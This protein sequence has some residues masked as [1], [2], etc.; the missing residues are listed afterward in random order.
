MRDVEAKSMCTESTWN[1]WRPVQAASGG[2]W[3][4]ICSK[5]RFWPAMGHRRALDGADHNCSVAGDCN[6]RPRCSALALPYRSRPARLQAPL[7]RALHHQSGDPG[8]RGE[9]TAPAGG[10]RRRGGGGRQR[11]GS[12]GSGGSRANGGQARACGGTHWRRCEDGGGCA[13]AALPPG[14]RAQGAAG[15]CGTRRGAFST[16]CCI[17]CMACSCSSP[18]AASFTC[19]LLHP[20]SSFDRLQRGWR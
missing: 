1:G 13:G 4:R 6:A 2:A 14:P 20:R 19:R 8:F 7:P 9:P 15:G 12:H 10:W 11:S 16:R 17:A 18:I 3:A 5:R